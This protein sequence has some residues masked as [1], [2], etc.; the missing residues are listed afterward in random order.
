MEVDL[1]WGINTAAS[2]KIASGYLTTSPAFDSYPLRGFFAL[3]A[4]EAFG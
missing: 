4:E 3:T 1:I 2:A